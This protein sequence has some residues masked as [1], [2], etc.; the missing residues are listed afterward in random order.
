MNGVCEKMSL[1]KIRFLWIFG[2]GS[3]IGGMVWF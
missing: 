1:A 2:L 3:G